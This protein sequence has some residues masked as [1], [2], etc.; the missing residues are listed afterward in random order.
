MDSCDW[1]LHLYCEWWEPTWSFY[2]WNQRGLHV[3]I[4]QG[5]SHRSV[6][7]NVILQVIVLL[8]V[9]HHI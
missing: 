3:R 2:H 1:K 8:Q 4:I 6:L 9:V 7:Q 5:F